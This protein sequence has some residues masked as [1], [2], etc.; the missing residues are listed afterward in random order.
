[1]HL[2]RPLLQASKRLRVA[3]LV[4]GGVDSCVAALL[5]KRQGFNVIGVHLKCWDEF[6]NGECSEKD[7]NDA[8]F[9]C[10]KLG[11]EF[12]EVNYV[13]EYWNYVF[14]DF[15]SS[16][17]RGDTP[18]IDVLCNRE[19][20][21]GRFIE[22]ALN[23]LNVDVVATGHYAGSSY[24]TFWENYNLNENY[25]VK[26]LRAKDRIRDQ[27]LF[28]S[29]IHYAALKKV[30]FPLYN[31][32]KEEVRRIAKDNGFDKITKRKPT[33]GICFIG[34]RNYQNF[35]DNYLQPKRG[36]MI[37]IDTNEIVCEHKGF[38]YW[39][40]GQR[41]TNVSLNKKYFIAHKCR[42]SNNIFIAGGVDHSSLYSNEFTVANIHWINGQP[43]ELESGSF[44]CM[45]KFQQK[46][47]LGKCNVTQLDSNK[48]LVKTK[49]MQR[50]LTPGQTS[51]FYLGDHC[52]GSA[53][54]DSYR[55]SYIN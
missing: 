4:S 35:I 17:K 8:S 55:N 46:E 45:F 1:M 22:Y 48:L 14:E 18:N 42:K 52:L 50:C 38:H 12:K 36:Y 33:T 39:T 43:K 24:G 7:R 2:L 15:L 9:V 25:S 47:I 11:I 13:K 31:L 41:C 20:K 16:Y 37:D 21:F 34:K 19:I 29:G 44:D 49:R 3:C 6:E 28:L 51:A 26:L 40:L 54:I 32:T 53:V 5:L 27:T 10:E 30:M 23:V